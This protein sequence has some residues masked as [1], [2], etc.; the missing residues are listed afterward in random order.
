[1]DTEGRPGNPVFLPPARQFSGHFYGGSYGNIQMV[2]IYIYVYVY[3]Y[4]YIY[5]TTLYNHQTTSS[6]NYHLSY[7]YIYTGQSKDD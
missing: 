6:T 2:Y 3:I 7:I 4:M 1:M 5:S